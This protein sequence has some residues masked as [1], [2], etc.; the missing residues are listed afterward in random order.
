[1]MYLSEAYILMFSE[2][3][4]AAGVV[5]MNGKGAMRN[6]SGLAIAFAAYVILL[7]KGLHL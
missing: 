2:L 4:C 6:A 1:M 5:I 7:G 3:A